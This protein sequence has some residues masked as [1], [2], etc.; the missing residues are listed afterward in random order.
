MGVVDGYGRVLQG[1]AAN[2]RQLAL[3]RHFGDGPFLG[4]GEWVGRTSI[5]CGKI[6]VDCSKLALRS[7]QMTLGVCCEIAG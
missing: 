1:P 2:V 5:I 7:K 4:A 6:G 3:L